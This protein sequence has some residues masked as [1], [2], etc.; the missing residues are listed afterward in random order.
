MKKH[1]VKEQ[2]YYQLLERAIDHTRIGV[3]ITDP[4]QPDNPIIYANEGFTSISGYDE[5][6][7]IGRNC[8]FLQGK[9]TDPKAVNQLRSAIKNHQSITIEILNYKKDGSTFW[10]E[11]HIDP[12]YIEEEEQYYFVGIQKDVSSLKSAEEN[13]T[14]YMKEIS[15]LSTPIVPIAEGI[16]VLPLIGSIDG[17][18]LH[19]ITNNITSELANRRHEFLIV[20]LSGLQHYD[21]DVIRGIYRLNDILQLLGTELVIAGISPDFALKSTNLDIDLSTLKTF[22]TV[23]EAIKLHQV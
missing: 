17:E 18:R 9:E 15:A 7:I 22:A 10:N 21:E 14:S 23:K 1:A 12:I 8:R 4:N 13:L 20:E 6:E 16:S 19:L 3:T 2:I 11:L 5:E